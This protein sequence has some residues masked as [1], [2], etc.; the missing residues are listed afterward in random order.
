M[1]GELINE[2]RRGMF[3]PCENQRSG[4]HG[5]LHAAAMKRR[6]RWGHTSAGSLQD[7]KVGMTKMVGVMHPC[8]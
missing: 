7:G 8:S 6:E 5:P 1:G 3:S 2:G 4:G